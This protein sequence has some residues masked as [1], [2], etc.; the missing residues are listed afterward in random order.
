MRRGLLLALVGVAAARG[1]IAQTGPEA[2]RL[3]VNEHVLGWPAADT[4][5]LSR[6]V[7][8]RSGC[9]ETGFY[10]LTLSPRSMRPLRVGE[11]VCELV[12][13]RHGA[14]ITGDG[15]LV[16]GMRMAVD[17]GPVVVNLPD[18]VVEKRSIRCR[19]PAF[20]PHIS[21]DGRWIAFDGMCE[22]GSHQ[23]AIHTMPLEGGPH[24]TVVSEPGYML[25]GPRWS[26]DGRWLAYVRA[27]E[28][29]GATGGEDQVA[30]VEV[31][32]GAPRVLATGRNPAWSADG[33]RLAY[34]SGDDIRV[35]GADGAGDRLVL[36]HRGRPRTVGGAAGGR[37]AWSP[38]GQWIAFSRS[39]P[40][41]QEVWRVHVAN[42]TL[43][44]LTGHPLD[45]G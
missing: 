22:E 9:A 40:N 17:F 32:G 30:V 1:A 8:G 31:D 36:R 28:P 7:V 35:V 19:L 6:Q 24:R 16:A 38:D 18:G 14:A 26:P 39:H 43:E 42:G 3:P 10:V 44:R 2:A 12:G 23:V 41:G 15:K 34:F 27:P 5:Y 4:L 13:A 29:G 20:E 33:G 25:L 45:G 37:L 21:P 11:G